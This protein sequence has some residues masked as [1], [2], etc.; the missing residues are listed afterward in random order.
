M[1]S[2]IKHLLLIKTKN[3]NGMRDSHININVVKDQIK[4][5]YRDLSLLRE[6]MELLEEKK[7]DLK[8]FEKLVKLG[9]RIEKGVKSPSTKAII[10]DIRE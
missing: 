4:T 10:D 2:L 3:I 7:V 6:R 1:Y 8:A 9:E 5:L